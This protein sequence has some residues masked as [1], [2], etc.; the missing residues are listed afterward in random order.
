MQRVFVKKN[1][2]IIILLRKNVNF[3]YYS[4]NLTF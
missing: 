3:E 2:L 1:Q 4:N